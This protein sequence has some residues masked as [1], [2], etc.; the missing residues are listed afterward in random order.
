L[1]VKY[2]CTK[3]GLEEYTITHNPLVIKKLVQLLGDA[4]RR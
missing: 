3:C 4:E 2:R 1:L